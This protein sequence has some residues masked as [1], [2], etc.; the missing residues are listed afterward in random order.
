M[1]DGD[2]PVGD[3]IRDKGDS[4]ITVEESQS[5]STAAQVLTHHRIG[6]LVVMSTERKFVGLLSERDIVRAVAKSP[7][8][9]SEILVGDLVTRN[10]TAC[11][12]RATV[13]DVL[14]TMRENGFRH[15]PVVD[16]GKIKG[17]ISRTDVLR[18]RWTD[19]PGD[20]LA[21]DGI[22]VDEIA[23]II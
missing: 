18:R 5:I 4:M 19:L 23:S 21:E 6:L 22:S 17:I 15:I 10:V 7:E 20:D 14:D 2:T 11:D 8:K 1:F 12:M 9:I 3:I 16:G 13:D